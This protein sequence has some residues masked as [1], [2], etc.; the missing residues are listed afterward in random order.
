MLTSAPASAHIQVLPT[1]EC[2]RMR[3]C[4]FTAA[5][6]LQLQ[7]GPVLLLPGTPHRL[8]RVAEPQSEVQGSKGRPVSGQKRGRGRAGAAAAA[9]A[10]AGNQ[11][12]AAPPT[13]KFV[14]L[15]SL[16]QEQ[17]SEHA[18]QLLDC[19][20]NACKPAAVSLA[21]RLVASGAAKGAQPEPSQEQSQPEQHDE[22]DA[23]G[24]WSREQMALL[25]QL[26]MGVLPGQSPGQQ[27]DVQQPPSKRQ[28][29]TRGGKQPAAAPGSEAGTS[30]AAA[31]AA[32]GS[33]S[34]SGAARHEWQL[35][36]F[37]K[38]SGTAGAAPSSSRAAAAG[39]EE[40]AVKLIS[41][42]AFD[43][44]GCCLVPAL[45]LQQPPMGITCAGDYSLLAQAT[46]AGEAAAS[47][48][49][50]VH[51]ASLLR[52]PLGTWHVV[53]QSTRDLKQ[54]QVTAQRQQRDLEQRVKRAE[55]GAGQ[56]LAALQGLQQRK[57]QADADV[58]AS[59]RE[60]NQRQGNLSRPPPVQ[61]QAAAAAAAQQQR[62]LAGHGAGNRGRQ[63]MLE[64]PWMVP[65]P[66]GGRQGQRG[67]DAPRPCSANEV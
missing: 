21:A 59:Q 43:A 4:P 51:A 29:S 54:R 40:G 3:C 66:Q 8:L 63:P 5:G 36:L 49:F 48:S 38:A 46:P 55:T 34:S 30:A 15:D 14:V 41:A 23:F 50:D 65:R 32:G 31:A 11:H 33:G 47:S 13:D 17:T 22:D 37:L 6:P 18:L 27:Q 12:A 44:E 58:K 64:H 52:L 62:L 1:A 45:S 25:Q 60:V 16:A 7:V 24:G 67:A 57:Q 19:W 2:C 39:A 26:S 42:L 56:L 9:A 20:G 61:L 28:R 53:S 35:C 10:G